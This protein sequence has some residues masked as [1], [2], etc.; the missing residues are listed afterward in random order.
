MNKMK[1]LLKKGKK[2][3][4]KTAS[5]KTEITTILLRVIFF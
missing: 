1:S 3:I 2:K 4:Y 5:Q